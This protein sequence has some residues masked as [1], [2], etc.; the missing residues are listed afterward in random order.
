MVARLRTSGEIARGSIFVPIH[1]SGSNAS[2]ARVGALVGPGVDPVSG[3][4]EFKNTPARVEPFVVNWYGFA[5]T[6][7]S[8]SLAA[9]SWWACAEGGQYRRYEIAGRSVPHNWSMWGRSLMRAESTADWIDYEDANTGTYRA[10]CLRDDRLEACLFVGPQPQ[11]LSRSWL[12]SLFDKPRL[13]AS[14]R[15]RVL[16]SRPGNPSLDSGVTVCACFGVGRNAIE[17][18]IADGCH[19]LSSIG[20][21]L[22]AG[23]NCG[24]C[25]PDAASAYRKCGVASV[26][27]ELS[28]STAH[29]R[30]RPP[31]PR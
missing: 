12:A 14:E 17:A 16:A 8:L 13:A 29:C 2:D 23:T 20:Y 3:E 9:L 6:R 22:R 11:L 4:P 18:A 21:R 5:L 28:A 24:S 15:A 31:V 30:V 27:G 25:V 26:G 1:W 10:A 19:D 7:G